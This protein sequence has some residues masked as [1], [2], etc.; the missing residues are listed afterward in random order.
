M[1]S[2]VNT[3]GKSK[4]FLLCSDCM[5]FRKM[6]GPNANLLTLQIYCVMHNY[7]KL[8]NHANIRSARTS[9]DNAK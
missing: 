5:V 3:K 8:L 7:A 4:I 1:Q 6:L 2:N 9:G